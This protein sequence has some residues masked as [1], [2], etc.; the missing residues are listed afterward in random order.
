MAVGK[1]KRMSKGGKRGKR[2][3]VEAMSR[4][5]WYDVVAPTTFKTRQFSKSLCNKTI[6]TKVASENIKGRVYEACLAD[7]QDGKGDHDEPYRNIKLKVHDVQGRSMLTQFHGM[8]LTADKYRALVRKWCTTI[9][10][11]V[12]AKTADGYHMRLFFLAFTTK[13]KNQLS[14]NCYANT[15]LIRWIRSRM[16]KI[17]QR[18]LA[19][20][21]I[22]GAV[23]LFTQDTLKNSIFK[24]CNPLFPLRDLKLRKVKVI[25][26]PKFELGKLNESHDPLPQSV[27]ELGRVVEE[28]AP[29]VAAAEE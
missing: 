29:V 5:E 21:D 12:E 20:V 28:A 13:Q 24:L 22:N 14:K 16:A 11:V 27:E 18:R 19:Q 2:K 9:E 7:L 8:N 6:G 3:V 17:A 4:K 25:K 15:R 10:S 23:K 1:N 26:Y